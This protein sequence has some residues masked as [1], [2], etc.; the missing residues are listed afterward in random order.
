MDKKFKRKQDFLK[1]HF[2]TF[3]GYE[4]ISN[5][6]LSNLKKA[7][8]KMGLSLKEKQYFEFLYEFYFK[9]DTNIVELSKGLKLLFVKNNLMPSV[10]LLRGLTE[11]IF[12]NIYVAFKSYQHIKKNNIEGLVDLI[13]RANMATDVDSLR[14]KSLKQESAIYKRI[15][16]K[17]NGKRIHI[18]DC[19]RFFKKDHIQKIIKT[20][21]NNKIDSY[22]TLENSKKGLTTGTFTMEDGEVIDLSIM[23]EVG[24]SLE[25]SRIIQAYDRMCEIIHPTAIKIYDA[26]DPQTQDDF[27]ELFMHILDSPLFPINC[28]SSSYKYFVI[29]NFVENK[30][31]FIKVFNEKLK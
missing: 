22:Q 30:E 16:N 23:T 2:F 20:K 25:R 17:Y 29:Y 18:N 5:D 11:L 14:S 24:L 4:K 3:D 31:N 15:I 13:L 28:F 8:N 21:E 9:I 26:T 6:Y 27:E 10:F 12:F 7:K 1:K 19:I